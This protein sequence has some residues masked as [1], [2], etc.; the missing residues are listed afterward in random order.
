MYFCRCPEY[1]CEVVP[2][3]P[4]SNPCLFTKN[5]NL[6]NV[7]VK[8]KVRVF[9]KNKATRNCRQSRSDLVEEEMII[10]MTCIFLPG[11]V[12]RSW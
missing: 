8:K 2:V 10:G 6:V 12:L 1:F 5:G 7:P 11:T 3:E 9:L 4:A